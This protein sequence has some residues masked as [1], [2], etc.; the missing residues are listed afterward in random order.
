MYPRM[1]FLNHLKKLLIKKK[2]NFQFAVSELEREYPD[3]SGWFRDFVSTISNLRQRHATCQDLILQSSQTACMYAW[4]ASVAL[5]LIRLRN[6]LLSATDR[7]AEIW[8]ELSE[9]FN[10]CQIDNPI[11]EPEFK[12]FLI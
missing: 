8:I 11:V 1:Y 3:L 12:L 9:A 2:H 10:K 7:G 5:E 6:N 4:S